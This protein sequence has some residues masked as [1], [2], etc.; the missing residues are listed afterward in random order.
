VVE[1]SSEVAIPPIIDSSPLI[2]LTK[3]NLLHLLQMFYPEVLVPSTVAS[4]SSTI[5]FPYVNNGDME[6]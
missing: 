5:K 6:D 4:V 3:A 2:L 1:Q